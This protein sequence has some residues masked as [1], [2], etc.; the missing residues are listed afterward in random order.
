MLHSL[1]VLAAETAATEAG[2]S[3]LGCAGSWGRQPLQR[4]GV[5]SQALLSSR[6]D[7]SALLRPHLEEGQN[8]RASCA[9]A[10][11]FEQQPIVSAEAIDAVE[12]HGIFHPHHRRGVVFL[13][14]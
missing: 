11:D 8:S 6:E 7:Q 13:L 2:A 10:A 12:P 1:A 14:L 4:R 5:P 3:Q 9:D